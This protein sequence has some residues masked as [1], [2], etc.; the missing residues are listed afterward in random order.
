[1]Q[2]FVRYCYT[3]QAL[4]FPHFLSEIVLGRL[5]QWTFGLFGTINLFIMN[6]LGSYFEITFY[7]FLNPMSVYEVFSS[8]LNWRHKKHRWNNKHLPN[9]L[10]FSFSSIVK[11]SGTGSE[12][13]VFFKASHQHILVS[14]LNPKV[15]K[16]KFLRH[17]S[18]GFYFF[19]IQWKTFFL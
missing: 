14:F 19:G 11:S 16:Q 12:Y 10:R 5:Q 6:H 4:K 17:F 1:M 9:F 3:K 7:V 2:A 13:S 8:N 15:W 18:F